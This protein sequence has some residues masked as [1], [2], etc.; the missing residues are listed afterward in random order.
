MADLDRARDDDAAFGALI[1]QPLAPW[2]R[3]L[4]ETFVTVLLGARQMGKSR[5]IV[6]KSLRLAVA[7]PDI[8]ILIASSS[9]DGAR[10][11][12]ALCRRFA[13]AFPPLEASF[14]EDLLGLITF[15]NGS[16]IRAIASSET[17]ARGWTADYLFGDEVQLWPR[18]FLDSLIP[19]LAARDG[20]MLLAGTAGIAEGAFFDFIKQGDVGS[21]HVRTHRW[22]PKLVGG[23]CDAPWLSASVIEAAKAVQPRQRFDAEFRC[24][25]G[26]GFDSVIPMPVLQGAI[27]DYKTTPMAEFCPFSKGSLGV[28][29]GENLD[30]TVEVRVDRFAG[31]SAFGISSVRRWSAGASLP[32]VIAEIANSP[33]HLQAVWAERNGIGA[34]LV[35]HLFQALANRPAAAGGGRLPPSLVLVEENAWDRP[36]RRPT[37]NFPTE[38]PIRDRTPRRTGALHA[39]ERR[40][41]FT[42]S[43]MKSSLFGAIRLMFEAGSLVIPACE[44]ELISEL[45]HLRSEPTATGERI[46]GHPHDDIV[47]ALAMACGPVRDR[48]K[49]GD[50]WRCRI[51]EISRGPVPLAEVPGALASMPTVNSDSGI[52]V[53]RDPV[54]QSVLS[55][56]VT[57]PPYFGRGRRELPLI[58]HARHR[59]ADA[60]GAPDK[61]P[62]Q[63]TQAF[64]GEHVYGCSA[65]RTETYE[66]VAAGG[67]SLAIVRCIECGSEVILP[68]KKEA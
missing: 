35:P 43:G 28:D 19:V 15:A 25:S 27:C 4:L 13:A 24:I 38:V 12:I 18:A 14:T 45:M 58:Q 31:Q 20:K 61:D 8:H 54:W 5:L 29:W 41:I 62:D 52:E 60:P 2:Q 3:V 11:L 44:T 40:A 48:Q 36:K 10:R 46:S 68:R 30:R 32:G 22:V 67:E 65:K 23:D 53:P 56:E 34:G 47:M 57:V 9:E 64:P 7:K 66:V 63:A 50:T 17:A 37:E 42:T 33:G 21:E 39:T 55:G 26:S 51:A 16:T 59:S 1:G 6:V 49:G